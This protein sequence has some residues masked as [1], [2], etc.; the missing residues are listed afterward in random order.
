MCSH[1]DEVPK[2]FTFAALMVFLQIQKGLLLNYCKCISTNRAEGPTQ[3]KGVNVCS[4]NI[5]TNIS[6]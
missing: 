1:K 2:C 6:T 4:S 5:C 3:T